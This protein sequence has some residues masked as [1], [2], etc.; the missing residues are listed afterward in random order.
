MSKHI[1][2]TLLDK[3]DYDKANIMLI[4]SFMDYG[5]G[6]LFSQFPIR[7]KLMKYDENDK[8]IFKRTYLISNIIQD[9]Q[10][11][12]VIEPI[13]EWEDYFESV[14]LYDSKDIDFFDENVIQLLR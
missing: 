2:S 3:K 8:P 1:A 7:N 4:H 6:V 13:G 10:G 12:Y 14:T 11:G 9:Y 5:Y